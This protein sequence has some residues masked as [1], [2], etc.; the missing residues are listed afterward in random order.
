MTSKPPTIVDLV[1]IDELK[2]SVVSRP[3]LVIDSAGRAGP[4]PV[5]ALGVALAGCMSVDVAHMLA[6]GRRPVRAL[7]SQLSGDRA[8]EEPRRFLRVTLHLTIEGDVPM[9]VVARAVRLSR[10]KYCSVWHS[11]R[12][13]I[14]L[15]T[16]FTITA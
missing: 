16:K 13:D 3:G 1:W 14:T 10:E 4:S 8:D 15:T 2:F 12:Q 7:R 11:M 6:R 9:E 5:E